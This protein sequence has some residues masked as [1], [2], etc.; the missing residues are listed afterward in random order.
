MLQ[1]V[2]VVT[3]A[4]SKADAPDNSGLPEEVATDSSPV[5]EQA[6]VGSVPEEVE[7]K[8]APKPDFSGEWKM[9]RYE[10]DFET[11]MKEAGVGWAS[12]KAASAAGFGVGGTFVS[13]QQSEK[14]ITI[15]SKSAI[16]TTSQELR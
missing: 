9:V 6:V 1:G 2:A 10:G 12:R 5:G 16:G 14:H 13:I 7:A 3:L 4:G 11:W 15:K 8:E